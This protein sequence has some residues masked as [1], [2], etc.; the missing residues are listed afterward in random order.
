MKSAE[1]IVWKSLLLWAFL[2]IATALAPGAPTAGGRDSLTSVVVEP[3]VT[4]MSILKDGPF[5]INVLVV[6]LNAKNLRLE[7]YRPIG[8]VPTSE[9]AK[10]NEREGHKVVAAINADF[11]SFK[12]GWP[13]NIQ[14]EN[15]EFVFGTQTQR[16]H[17]I[18]DDK[19][20]PHIE[21]TNFDGWVKPVRGK[22][23][24][25]SGIN[26][27]HKD[28]AIILHTSFS[29]TATSSAGGGKTVS[30][31][32][33]NSSWSV[34][35]TLRMVVNGSGSPDL[36]HIPPE[37]AALWIGNGPSV[38]SAGEEMKFGDTV[39]VYLGIRPLIRNTRTILGGVGMIV[40]NGKPVSDSVNVGEKTNINFLTA[41][42]PRTFV[43]FDRDSTKL[44]L[45]V[46][47]GRQQTSVGMN[48][49]EMAEFLLSIGVWNAVNFDGGGSTTMVIRGK[50]VNS[51]SDKTGERP[52]ANSFQVISLGPPGSVR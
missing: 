11:F 17:L 20:R 25:I 9:Q 48:F 23:Y 2:V 43:G 19:N 35:D 16:S 3:G 29:D 1:K 38:S 6:D 50:I 21:R 33:L 34:C 46:V 7:S 24:T 4:H 30:L 39:L 13:V 36:T 10:R 40:A 26:D 8:L 15:G 42:H 18:L 51:P 27:V 47:D 5:A 28:D 52:V 49:R 32:L 37:E 14:V 44:F 31:N 22:S 12:T 45:C 41:R